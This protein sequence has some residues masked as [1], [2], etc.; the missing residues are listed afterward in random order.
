M[1]QEKP[2]TRRFM[3]N[4]KRPKQPLTN[5]KTTVDDIREATRQ[6]GSKV[7]TRHSANLL[8]GKMTPEGMKPEE[9]AEAMAALEA[10]G[11]D[12]AARNSNYATRPNTLAT[13]RQLGSRTSDPPDCSGHDPPH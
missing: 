9:A 12:E 6:H 2:H 1:A 13:G 11:Q 3:T 7:G 10:E 4:P 8:T 5:Q